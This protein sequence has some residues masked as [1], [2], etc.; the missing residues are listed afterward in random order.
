MFHHCPGSALLRA[1]GAG[2]WTGK[3]NEARIGALRA[4]FEPGDDAPFAIPAARGMVELP[5]QAPLV[6]GFGKARL[7]FALPVFDDLVQSRIAHTPIT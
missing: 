6:A 4:K 5:D 1:C 2:G 7:Q 3:G